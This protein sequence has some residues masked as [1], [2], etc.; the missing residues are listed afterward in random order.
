MYGG[1]ITGIVF[2]AKLSNSFFLIKHKFK[3][4]ETENL[5]RVGLTINV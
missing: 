5:C 3:K 1:A 4:V 2:L